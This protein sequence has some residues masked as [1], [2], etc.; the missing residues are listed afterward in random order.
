GRAQQA[1]R[2][3]PRGVTMTRARRIEGIDP[4]SSLRANAALIIPARVRELTTWEQY[5]EDPNRVFE[6][7]QMRIAAK[8]L[9]YTL[10]LFAPVDPAALGPVIERVKAI[11]EQLGRIHDADVLV[12]LLVDHLRR[13]LRPPGGRRKQDA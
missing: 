12:P 2:A 11:Q 5:V 1:G 10:E 13:N 9:R 4:N 7:H 3:A 8:R 6:L